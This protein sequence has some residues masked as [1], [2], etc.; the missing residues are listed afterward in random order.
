MLVKVIGPRAGIGLTGIIGG[1]AS[2]TVTT[3]S[4]AKRSTE[5]PD[6]NGSFAVAVILAS[7]VMFPRLLLEISM[8][9]TQLTKSMVVPMMVMGVTG[10]IVAAFYHYRS[11]SEH[12]EG[13]E[14]KLDNL[15]SRCS[16]RRMRV[17]LRSL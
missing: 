2:S 4:F 17:L 15:G 14:L 5:V 1:L 9:N 3:L 12:S 16:L 8:V 10:L 13:A 7:S 11:R 6:W